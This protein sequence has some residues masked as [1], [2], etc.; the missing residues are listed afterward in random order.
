MAANTAVRI[1]PATCDTVS[2]SVASDPANRPGDASSDFA[3]D[4]Q[5]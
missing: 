5:T 1:D 3:A 4:D 2:V